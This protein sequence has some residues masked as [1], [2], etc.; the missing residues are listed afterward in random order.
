MPFDTTSEGLLYLNAADYTLLPINPQ[1][2]GRFKVLRDFK[3]AVYPYSRCDTY[4]K[5]LLL[6][7]DLASS[8]RFYAGNNTNPTG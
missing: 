5:I 7:R 4:K 6:Q 3:M 8:G 1:Q 2:P